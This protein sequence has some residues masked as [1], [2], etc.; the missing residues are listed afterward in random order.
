MSKR[1][2]KIKDITPVQLAYL[3]LEESVDEEDY[4][5]AAFWRDWIRQENCPYQKNC[6]RACRKKENSL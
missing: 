3:R 6:D 4:E 5:T 1:V 2:L